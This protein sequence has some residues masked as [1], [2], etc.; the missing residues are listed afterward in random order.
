MAF[1]FFGYYPTKSPLKFL[2]HNR[3]AIFTTAA[4][5]TFLKPNTM[6]KLLY[7][8]C[9]FPLLLNAQTTIVTASGM[10]F[11][12]ADI[13]ITVGE[14]VQWD[15]VSGTHN[16]N[17]SQ[18]IFPGNPEEFNSGGTAPAPWSFS[19]TFNVAGEYDYR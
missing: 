13:T 19:H 2:I 6:K 12:P 8:F 14:T 18:D 3:Y 1:S 5:F 17:G 16:V 10:T 11:T 9:F 7:F 4:F 15:N